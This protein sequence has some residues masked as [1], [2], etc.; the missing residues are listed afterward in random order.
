MP[1]DVRARL[2]ARVMMRDRLTKETALQ[3]LNRLSPAELTRL[4]MEMLDHE[5]P[6]FTADYDPYART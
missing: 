6:A 2:L 1:D 4:E 3:T 5:R